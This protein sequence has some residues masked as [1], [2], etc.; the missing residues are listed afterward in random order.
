MSKS[1]RTAPCVQ[2][3]LLC[4]RPLFWKSLESKSLFEYPKE[5][6]CVQVSCSESFCKADVD[7]HLGCEC[8]FSIL[9]W[10]QV[11]PISPEIMKDVPALLHWLLNHAVTKHL[12]SFGTMLDTGGQIVSPLSYVLE[13]QAI[14]TLPKTFGRPPPPGQMTSRHV[15]DLPLTF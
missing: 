1:P 14:Q 12:L 4:A 10:L 3:P 8:T 5:C 13:H 15:T 6:H 7:I 9:G 2:L 11:K